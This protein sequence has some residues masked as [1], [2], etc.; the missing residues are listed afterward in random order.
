MNKIFRVWDVEQKRYDTRDFLL[1]NEGNIFTE[2]SF[3]YQD[4][5]ECW[6]RD[7]YVVEFYTGLK[8]KNSREIYEGD[9]VN[10][11]KSFISPMDRTTVLH[12]DQKFIV[13][14]NNGAYGLRKIGD[15]ID[16]HPQPLYYD[17]DHIEV[18]GNI[19]EHED[20]IKK[21]KIKLSYEVILKW[22][23]KSSIY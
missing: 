21:I 23:V 22:L 20:L 2:E 6:K 15:P 18:I 11:K 5:L 13:D 14:K 7:S 19:Y 1:G 10:L 3:A 16:K 12:L 17:V 9:I 4:Y 8:D